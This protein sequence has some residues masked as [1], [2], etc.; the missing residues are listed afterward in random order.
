M[1]TE[2]R[3][4]DAAVRFGGTLF[5]SG[6][7]S[8]SDLSSN[9]DREF[10]AVSIDSRKTESGDLF[11]ALIGERLDAHKYLDQVAD[12]ASGAVV[13]KVDKSLPLAQWV[14][15]DTTVALGQLAQLQRDQFTGTVVAVTAFHRGQFQ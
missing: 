11:V 8:G 6:V 4:T 3:L 2:L 12:K 5:N 10:N 14:V 9:F 7:N 13:S 1:I 15:E